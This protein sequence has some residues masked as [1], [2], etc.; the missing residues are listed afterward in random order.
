MKSR[1]ELAE[2]SRE[3]F[4]RVL[5]ELVEILKELAEALEKAAKRLEH[6]TVDSENRD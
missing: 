2:E 6:S 5:A 1:E 4:S 3:E